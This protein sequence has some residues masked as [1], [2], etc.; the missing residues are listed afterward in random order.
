LPPI[1]APHQRFQPE[2]GKFSSCGFPRFHLL[3][4]YFVK[5]HLAIRMTPAMAAGV[6]NSH[7]TVAEFVERCG[8]AM[9]RFLI[10]LDTPKP[11]ALSAD[12]TLMARTTRR[13][14]LFPFWKSPPSG[15]TANRR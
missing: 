15:F 14:A 9:L 8:K 13:N 6:E 2:T 1:D 3:L 5:T 12:P 11:S 4:F 10:R 7:W